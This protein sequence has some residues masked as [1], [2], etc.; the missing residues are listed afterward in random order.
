MPNNTTEIGST[1]LAQFSG[2]IQQDFL[3]ELR[4]LEGY[5]KFDE[6]R[7]NSPVVGALLLA[8]RQPILA[9]EWTFNSTV[10]NDPRLEICNAALENMSYSM[11]D[12][13][14]EALCFL[15]AGYYPFEIVYERGENGWMLWRKF[16]PRG[17]DTV[18]RWGFGEDGGITGFYQR[19]NF[20]EEKFIPIEKTIL[21]RINVERNN[22]EGRS[23]LRP[24]WTS[25]YYAKYIQQAE[26]IGL[27]RGLDGF[28]II[29][30]PEGANT[31]E[32]N[33]NSDASKAAEFVRNVRND[34]Q[35]GMVLP[36]GWDFDLAAPGAQSRLDADK[37]IRRYES[38][39]LMSTLTQFLNLGQEAVGSLSLSKDQT[40]FFT[41][42]V[43]AIADVISGTITKHALPKLMKMNGYDAVGLSLTH[44]PANQEDTQAIANALQSVG[45]SLIHI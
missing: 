40:D 39:I 42:S 13:V 9:M 7:S 2:R 28:P 16:S 44:S 5:R 33:S 24:A 21:Y 41:M 18:I 20:V 19:V 37:V 32:D 26:A 43:N 35:A 1:G 4:G 6:M 34:E 22:P 3:K 15:W 25:Y 45:L 31:D 38:R 10:E 27:E 17:Q 11:R 29:K 14:S 23:I 30:L 12:H 8:I 36:F